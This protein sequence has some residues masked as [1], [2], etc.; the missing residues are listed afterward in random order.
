MQIGNGDELRLQCFPDLRHAL[1]FQE[2]PQILHLHE[3]AGMHT[4]NLEST[5]EMIDLICRMRAYHPETSIVCC[6]AFSSRHS[7]R[8][9]YA[10][11]AIALYPSML[12]QPSKNSSVAPSSKVSLGLMIT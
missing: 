5:V 7:T 1:A 11:V 4:I 10:R 8:T 12:R 6:S 2:L 3:R 9:S